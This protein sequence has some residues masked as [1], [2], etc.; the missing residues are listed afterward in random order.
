M[1][2]QHWQYHNN[3]LN[4]G[5]LWMFPVVHDRVRRHRGVVGKDS[6]AVFCS[7]RQPNDRKLP[8]AECQTCK[9]W[10]HKKCQA[11]PWP[12]TKG[13]KFACHDCNSK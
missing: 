9:E 2:T 1:G 11:M 7:C 4:V 10:Y 5:K 12:I 6:V 3:C 8:M 13:T